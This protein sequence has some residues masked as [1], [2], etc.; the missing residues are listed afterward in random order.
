MAGSSDDRRA[1]AAPRRGTRRV[2]AALAGAGLAGLLLGFGAG[3]GAVS[4]A[5]ASTTPCGAR[6]AG[7][8]TLTPTIGGHQRTVIVHVPSG[9]NGRAKTP[10]VLDMHGS[11]ATAFDQEL[12]TG[13]DATADAD[14]FIVAYP[15]GLIPEGSGFDWNVPGEPLVGGAAVPA[16]AAD[17]VAFLTQLVGV[18]EH[19]LLHR[20]GA[21]LRDRLLGRR[22]HRQPA[23]LRLLEGLR[24]RRRGQRPAPAD[25]LPDGAPG[26]GH[27]LPRHRR[28]G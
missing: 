26:A 20:P 17:D 8:T 23:R 12:F 14:H 2:A 16:R 13:M 1:C 18:L 5:S 7:S 27:R 4:A 9:Y 25:A 28:P 15:Q 24:R 21:R 19:A 6:P 10:L 11:G 3:A 22:P